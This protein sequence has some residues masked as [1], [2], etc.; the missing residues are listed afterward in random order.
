MSV[1]VLMVCWV[2]TMVPLTVG[3]ILVLNAPGVTE[4]VR[5][6]L[7][8]TRVSPVTAWESYGMRKKEPA[9][10][11]RAKAAMKAM[12]SSNW[13]CPL[14]GLRVRVA[15]ELWWELWRGRRMERKLILLI[16]C[17]ILPVMPFAICHSLFLVAGGSLWAL[18]CKKRH[19][20]VS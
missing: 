18:L 7:G 16:L 3:V 1:L 4:A 5:L 13:T 2:E 15:F 14:V 12:K 10:K 19:R 20:E 6:A 8:E 11:D 9:I 17:L